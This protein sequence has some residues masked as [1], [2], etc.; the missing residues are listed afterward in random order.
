ME[1]LFAYIFGIYIKFG[2]KNPSI[3]TPYGSV[4]VAIQVGIE[5]C[6]KSCSDVLSRGQKIWKEIYGI[7]N[8]S[9]NSNKN[10]LQE[11][12]LLK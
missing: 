7:L 5:F 10:H 3:L 12:L 4:D 8:S 9:K 2:C 11:H 1:E 6:F